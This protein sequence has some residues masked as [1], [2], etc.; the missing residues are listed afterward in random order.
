MFYTTNLSPLLITKY[1]FMLIIILTNYQQ[2]PLPLMIFP[3]R[4]LSKLPQVDINSKLATDN[5]LSYT[6]GFNF[7]D[8]ELHRAKS[9]DSV[10]RQF[11]SSSHCEIS[12]QPGGIRT[13]NLVIARVLLDNAYLLC[14]KNYFQY[15]LSLPLSLKRQTNKIKTTENLKLTDLSDHL[16]KHCA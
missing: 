6:H 13:H 5:S 16:L 2:C 12:G 8:Y 14:S 4:E 7:F 10:T 9:F 3:S 1:G 11:V 15:I